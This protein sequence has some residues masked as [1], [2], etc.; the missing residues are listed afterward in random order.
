[1]T[2]DGAARQIPAAIDYYDLFHGMDIVDTIVEVGGI[3]GEQVKL[4]TLSLPADA[5]S[6]LLVRET[7]PGN[8][9]VNHVI[10]ADYLDEQMWEFAVRHELAHCLRRDYLYFAS[11]DS[12]EER[13]A[14]AVAAEHVAD[15]RTES[16]SLVGCRKA[17]K[18]MAAAELWCETFATLLGAQAGAPSR[19]HRLAR[20]LQA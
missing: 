4:L 17:S 18:K 5:P 13:S 14:L 1:M 15:E 16:L 10:V 8:L 3:V 7:R 20:S 19:Y 11:D 12:G 6:G 9:V 2:L